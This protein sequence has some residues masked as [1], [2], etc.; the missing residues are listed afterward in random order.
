ML[1]KQQQQ[2]QQHFWCETIA[3]FLSPLGLFLLLLE[4]QEEVQQQERQPQGQQTGRE[5]CT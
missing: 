3:T 1:I 4:E 5:E 2:Q